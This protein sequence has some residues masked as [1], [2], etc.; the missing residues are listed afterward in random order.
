VVGLLAAAAA[1]EGPSRPYL[2]RA[3]SDYRRACFQPCR[4]NLDWR[5]TLQGRFV[6]TPDASDPAFRT[7][8]VTD[9]QL[10]A[11]TLGEIH[12]GAGTY[13]LAG[14]PPIASSLHLDLSINDVTEHYDSGLT[15]PPPGASAE[16]PVIALAINYNHLECH[17]T[18]FGLLASPVADWNA[19][20]QTTV[21]DI[22]AFL[23][24]YF[25]GEGDLN[26]DGAT[27]VDEIFAFLADYF[28]RD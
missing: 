6:L 12:S 20:G 28:A 7:F 8:T 4:C 18:V 1:A 9:A 16:W 2:V 22:F 3:G 25:S 14:N 15:V 10:V 5:D 24:D 27:S 17:D 11:P 23:G 26:G 13:Q 19:S 21:E